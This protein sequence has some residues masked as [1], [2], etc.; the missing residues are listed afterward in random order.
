M[1]SMKVPFPEPT[2]DASGNKTSAYVYEPPF[3]PTS[4][5]ILPQDT[6]L[7]SRLYSYSAAS[8]GIAAIISWE[9]DDDEID[10]FLNAVFGF[11][12]QCHTEYCTQQTG[13]RRLVMEAL[14]RLSIYLRIGNM[15]DIS[16]YLPRPIIR[17]LDI[18]L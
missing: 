4:S 9:G 11:A 15:V 6:V 13:V 3:P 2:I 5:L 7:T 14:L 1:I 10:N 18:S 8:A 12:I 17:L 16:S